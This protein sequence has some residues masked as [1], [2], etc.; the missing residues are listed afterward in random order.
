MRGVRGKPQD[1][2]H[3][4]AGL[5]ALP[6][7]RPYLSLCPAHASVLVQTLHNYMDINEQG[8]LAF[9]NLGL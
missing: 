1:A 7:S 3:A 2:A 4:S 5:P 8:I 9:T 6:P